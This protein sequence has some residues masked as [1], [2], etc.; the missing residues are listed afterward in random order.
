MKNN[1]VEYYAPRTNEWITCELKDLKNGYKYKILDSKGKP[2]LADVGNG[3][4]VTERYAITDPYINK[5]GELHIDYRSGNEWKYWEGDSVWFDVNSK[6][7]DTG[8]DDE[9]W[10]RICLKA[11]WVITGHY[12]YGV[13]ANGLTEQIEHAIYIPYKAIKSEGRK[14]P[15]CTTRFEDV[16]ISKDCEEYIY[17]LTGEKYSLMYVYDFDEKKRT[18]TFHSMEFS[19]TYTIEENAL[20]RVYP[21]Y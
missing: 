11:T 21:I 10:N 14:A 3:I 17:I 9:K 15:K 16:I 19:D 7:I 12:K 4:K 6:E 13:W 20:N 18:I 5:N 2:I 1:K 8:F